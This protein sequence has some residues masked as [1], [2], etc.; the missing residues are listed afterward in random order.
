V[1]HLLRPARETKKVEGKMPGGVGEQEIASLSPG[2]KDGFLPTGKKR[3]R[4]DD[5][6]RTREFPLSIVQKEKTSGM[7]SIS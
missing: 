6:L 2:K 7:C 1:R 4:S 3:R 5:V